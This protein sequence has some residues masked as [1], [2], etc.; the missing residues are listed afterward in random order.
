MYV[1]VWEFEAQP[2][3]Q[4]EFEHAYGPIGAWATLFRQGE[5]FMELELL[6]DMETPGRYLTVDRWESQAHFERFHASHAAEYRAIDQ[7]CTTL[8]KRE[9]RL[10][11]FEI[12]A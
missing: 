2:H 1:V 9:T 4:R 8:T 3:Q 12:K 7:A 5:G 6:R 11:A 10:G